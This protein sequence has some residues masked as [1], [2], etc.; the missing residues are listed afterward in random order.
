MVNGCNYLAL[1]YEW[2]TTLQLCYLEYN[3]SALL[4]G[5]Q[6]FSFVTWNTTLNN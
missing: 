6:R 5:V 4:L 2:S 1:K 3:A